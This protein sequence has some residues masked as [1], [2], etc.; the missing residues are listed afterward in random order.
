MTTTLTAFYPQIPG[1]L[2]RSP[3]SEPR[4][5]VVNGLNIPRPA[6]QI[7]LYTPRFGPKT[8]TRGGVELVARLA[9]PSAGIK[10]GVPA[11]VELLSK[12]SGG[13]GIPSDGVVL[14]GDG[15]GAAALNALWQDV[16]AGR[17][18]RSAS[19]Q[20]TTTPNAIEALAGKPILVRDGRR[21]VSS[22]SQRNART[23]IGWNA[24]GDLLLVTVD[25]K[26]RGR[27]VGLSV[28]EAAK[29]MQML[30][31]VDAMNLDGGGSTTFVMR[32][33]LMNRPSTSSHR[34]RAV[35]VA[36]AIVRG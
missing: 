14:S 13:S 8:A 34:E 10:S 25:G 6:D 29:L 36:V 19:I 12:K 11:T 23:L 22:G 20:V 33:R 7:V 26:Q 1:L 32:G 5:T 28:V 15:K 35:A 30:G 24:R 17:A 16:V 21:V 9:A 31:A 3:S 2:F 27:S 18:E 4:S